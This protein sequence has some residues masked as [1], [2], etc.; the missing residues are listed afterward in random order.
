[1]SCCP[2]RW[3]A[4]LILLCAMPEAGGAPATG[5]AASDDFSTPRSAVRAFARA[6]LAHDLPALKSATTGGE[7][8]DFVLLDTWS[9]LLKSTAALNAV[10]AERFGADG[11]VVLRFPGVAGIASDSD[12]GDVKVDDDTATVAPKSTDPAKS[13]PLVLKKVAGRW[14]VDLARLPG[15]QQMAGASV[16]FRAMGPLI[17]QMAHDVAAG[18]YADAQETRAAF[19]QAMQRLLRP[20]ARLASQRPST[21]PAADTPPAKFAVP[22]YDPKKVD[23]H[24]QDYDW[25][26][27][28]MT[29]ELVLKLLDREPADY[30]VLQDKWKNKRDGNF[31]DFDGRT[32]AGVTFHKQFGQ[33][34]GPRFP[35]DDLFKTIDDELDHGRYVIISLFTGFSYHMYVIVGRTASGDYHA[36]SKEGEQTLTVTNVK[37]RVREI[38][39]TDIVTYTLGEPEGGKK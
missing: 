5:P 29:I 20:P 12:I 7:D 27:I 19:A 3:L 25:S 36:V 28:P 13:P 31:A 4:A 11:A 23:A 38:G 9:A 2:R 22:G 30:F 37:A 16:L 32:I 17:D 10:A 14:K 21:R 8:A 6:M 18:R 33:P 24:R 15:K 39:G 35:I 26:C 1:M 34:R